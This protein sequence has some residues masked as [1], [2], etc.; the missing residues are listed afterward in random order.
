MFKWYLS[1]IPILINI[2]LIS[3]AQNTVSEEH[4]SIP[5]IKN[6]NYVELDEVVIVGKSEARRQ[7]EQAFAISVAD[8]S[9]NYNT[10]VDIG[11]ITNRMAGVKL[12]VNGGVGSD[13]NFT[14]N[15]FSGRQVKFFMDGLAMD[16]FGDAFSIN[17][18]PANMVERVEVYKGVLPIGLGADALGGAVNVITR[19]TANYLDV[20]YSFGSFNTH[21]A[22]INGAYTNGKT[23][24]TTR[25]TSFLNYSDNN[26]KVYV[27]IIDLESGQKL[28]NQWVKRFHDGYKSLG[29]RL[30]TG[31]VNRPF[32]D[33]LLAGIIV[34][35]NDKDIQNGVVMDLVYGARTTDSRSVIPMLRYKKSDLFIEGLG[36]SFYGSYSDVDNNSTD[37]VPRR[38]NW[39]G[40]WVPNASTSSGERSR[41]QLHINNKEWRTNTSLNYT[42]NQYHTLSLNHVYSGLTRKVSDVEDPANEYNKVPQSIDK[43][44]LIWDGWPNI[45]DG[46]LPCSKGDKACE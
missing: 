3:E 16:N 38:Y 8:L 14:L 13:Y 21:K 19:K 30:E 35:G 9:K 4:T 12:R 39:Q 41:S 10:S 17:N 31:F 18:L 26:Y 22:S 5:D 20:S 32:A 6:N 29:V 23:G 46:M 34:A 40:E 44:Y 42:F 43:Q 11:T 1:V 45:H 15:G 2:P 33:Y 7:Q 37:T 36:L 28:G 24:L 27:P 25:L